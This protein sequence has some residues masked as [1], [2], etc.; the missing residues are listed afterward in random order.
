MEELFIF[1]DFKFGYYNF[2]KLREW[3]GNSG[4]DEYEYSVM[5]KINSDNFVKCIIAKRIEDD[6][7][8]EVLTHIK[9]VNFNGYNDNTL[10]TNYNGENEADANDIF[11]LKNQ[12][13]Q[14]SKLQ[15]AGV[16]LVLSTKNVINIKSISETDALKMKE[17]IRS[18]IM[19]IITNFKLVNNEAM[20]KVLNKDDVIKKITE[21]FDMEELE[22][23]I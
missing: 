11:N 17:Y 7:Y 5:D 13:N 16:Y 18:N 22:K 10:I 21:L 6:V 1:Y 19:S 4:N 2:R 15:T 8:E 3:N 14:A 12:V 23:V 20:E 9:F